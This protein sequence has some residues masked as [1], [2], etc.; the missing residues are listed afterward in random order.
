MASGAVQP[1]SFDTLP[2]CVLRADWVIRTERCGLE[3]L[4]EVVQA[5]LARIA[6][7]EQAMDEAAALNAA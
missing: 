7:W 5:A 6:H 3:G 1:T 2:G 4:C